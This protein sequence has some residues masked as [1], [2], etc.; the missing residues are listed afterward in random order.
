MDKFSTSEKDE[1]V[2]LRKLGIY[3]SYDKSNDNYK[4][5]ADKY[6]GR[7]T[8]GSLRTTQD[9][10]LTARNEISEQKYARELREYLEKNLKIL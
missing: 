2:L 9:V 7:R 6:S 8:I 10:L 5:R 3:V 1:L 4:I